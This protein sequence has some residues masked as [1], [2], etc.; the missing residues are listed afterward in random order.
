MRTPTPSVYVRGM[1]VYTPE[2]RLTNADLTR[3]VDTSDEWIRTRTGIIER[4]L[5]DADESAS[6]MA[7]KAGAKAIE[8]AGISKEEIDLII[9]ATA[10][11]DHSFPSTACRTQAKLGIKDVP[12]FDMSAAC[13]GF[14]YMMQ[15]AN[16]MLRAGDYRNVLIISTEK[17]SSIVN[18][19]DRNT[20]VLFGD[21]AAAFVLTK[22]NEPYVGIL[23]N[24]LG[25]DGSSG[26]LLSLPAGGSA[27]PAS[28]ETVHDGG[29]YLRMAGQEVFKV[30][31][32]TMSDCCK[33]LL[34]KCNVSADE[35]KCV[36]PHQAN[37]RIIDAVAR[38]V[39]IPLEKFCVNLQNYGNTSS[40]TIP[41][42]MKEAYD[43]GRF[44]AG[45]LVLL[46]A[47]GGGFTW[48]ATLIRWK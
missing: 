37:L 26:D 17:L 1:G 15:V 7:A 22:C 23:G 12:A 46:T 43:A 31:V 39:G 32:R 20:C 33:R 29:H 36:I 3:L 11:P 6:D 5:A 30:A 48:G 4:R 9:V 45:D 25:A 14:I 28:Y 27:C 16:H 18:W 34:E 8:N 40:A 47:F 13:S 10:T 35:I 21:A 38:Q 44:K 2:R 42:C 19:E 41:N 24:I